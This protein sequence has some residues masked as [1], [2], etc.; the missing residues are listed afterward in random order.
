VNERRTT[1]V[2]QWKS[3]MALS[4]DELL[5]AWKEAKDNCGLARSQGARLQ[6]ARLQDTGVADAASWETLIEGAAASRFGVGR[7]LERYRARYS[8]P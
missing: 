4:D 5:Q 6:D 2:D 7:H 1:D 8:C 3:L